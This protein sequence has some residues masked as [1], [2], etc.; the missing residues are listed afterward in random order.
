MYKRQGEE[1]AAVNELHPFREGNGR[2][3]RE[4]LNQL[5]GESGRSLDY[6]KVDKT[7]W[8]TAARLSAHGNIEPIKQV[9]YEISR[10]ERAVAFDAIVDRSGQTKALAAHPELDGAIKQ[11]ILTER[12]GGNVEKMR[13]ELSRELNDGKIVAGNVTVEESRRVMDMAAKHRGLIVRDIERLGGQ[14]DGKV[15][16]VS[17]HHAMLQVGDMV[18]VRYERSNLA[19]DIDVGSRVNI[20]YGRDQSQVYAANEAPQ[21]DRGRDAMQME[22]E[23]GLAT[24]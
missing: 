17:S 24:P 20:H 14:F 16:A 22:R 10:V 18:A 13:A 6:E 5:S 1:Y 3:A 8:N 11:L 2:T 23:R 12:A 9:F 15:V 21:R 4:F 7:T 19:R